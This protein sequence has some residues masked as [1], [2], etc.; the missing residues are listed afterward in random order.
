ME[1]PRSRKAATSP[2]GQ[3]AIYQLKIT[4]KYISPPIWRRVLV[5]ND[6]TLTK[7]HRI[8]QVVMGW[9]D[10]HLH[11]FRTKDGVAYGVPH[12][13]GFFFGPRVHSE[14]GARLHDVLTEER[15]GM[16]YTYDFGDSWEHSVVLEKVLPVE[17]G[18]HYP[19]C[20]KG[21]R[22]GPPEDVG[23]MPGYEEFVEAMADPEHEEHE[24]YAEWIGEEE[25]DSEAFDIEGVNARLK[26]IR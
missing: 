6:I 14:S 4:L 22:A 25:F 11:E 7:L 2:K 10:S 19:V 9:T 17:P 23:G 18:L 26:T 15:E 13:E 21:K 1:S 5:K 8:I 16:L 12:D 20:I 3:A 24:D